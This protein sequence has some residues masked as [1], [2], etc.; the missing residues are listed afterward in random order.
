MAVHSGHHGL[1]R[2][3]HGGHQGP[4]MNQSG[5]FPQE[6]QR[7]AGPFGGIRQIGHRSFGV[8]PAD[9]HGIQARQ[10]TGCRRR[11]LADQVVPTAIRRQPTGIWNSTQAGPGSGLHPVGHEPLEG[12][13]LGE[14]H[15]RVS[16]QCQVEADASG[17]AQLLDG[18]LQRPHDEGQPFRAGSAGE[19]GIGNQASAQVVP[20]E[21]IQGVAMGRQISTGPPVKHNSTPDGKAC[22]VHVGPE[23]RVV[24]PFDVDVLP[25][26]PVEPD[27]RV[28]APN[29]PDR[30]CPT[31]EGGHHGIGGMDVFGKLPGR[32]RHGTDRLDRS[33]GMVGRKD[34][35]PV[36][37]PHMG[38]GRVISP[39]CADDGLCP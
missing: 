22:G 3:H 27:R 2:I 4:R 30:F 18:L 23:G 25:D 5:L 31:D 16:V 15:H 6:V 1:G 12:F 38:P 28:V 29:E 21:C 13:G 26:D 32:R 8:R 36:V 39:P 33:M 7:I 24:D 19:G 37:Q 11:D 20:I 17:I 9:S 34:D 10:H 14:R 35:F